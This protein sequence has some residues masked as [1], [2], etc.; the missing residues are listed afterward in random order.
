MR[1]RSAMMVDGR[2]CY[3]DDDNTRRR[4]RSVGRAGWSRMLVQS[5]E[6]RHQSRWHMKKEERTDE[7]ARR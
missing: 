2:R 1:L 4:N 3:G 7:G 5:I 6:Q